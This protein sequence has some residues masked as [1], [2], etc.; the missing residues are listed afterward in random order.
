VKIG[1][2]RVRVK[3]SWRNWNE[4]LKEKEGKE[5]RGDEREDDR[6]DKGKEVIEEERIE[7]KRRIGMDNDRKIG[8]KGRED[9]REEIDGGKGMGKNL[10]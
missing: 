3:G 1:I 4:M 10:E 2:G 7:R 9:V 8:V 5:N 6:R